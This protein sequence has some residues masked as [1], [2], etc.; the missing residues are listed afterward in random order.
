MLVAQEGVAPHRVCQEE[1]AAVAVAGPACLLLAL[2]CTASPK[3]EGCTQQMESLLLD[4]KPQLRA[5]ESQGEEPVNCFQ[6]EFK[7]KP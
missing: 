7:A 1:A 2:P 6:H 5:A 3:L 4:S